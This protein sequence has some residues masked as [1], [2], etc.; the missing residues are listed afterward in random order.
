MKANKN[1]FNIH[2]KWNADNEQTNERYA[3]H[4]KLL[5]LERKQFIVLIEEFHNQ[6]LEYDTSV[7]EIPTNLN[8]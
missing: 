1:I 6:I 4:D 8:Y 7:Y 5:W 2:C 3:L